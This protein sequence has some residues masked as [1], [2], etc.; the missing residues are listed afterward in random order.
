MSTALA[1]VGA[2]KKV[3]ESRLIIQTL[4]KWLY[5][6]SLENFGQR[7]P[8]RQY[9]ED[10]NLKFD[11]SHLQRLF[12]TCLDIERQFLVTPNSKIVLDMGILKLCM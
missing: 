6:C 2:L 11:I 7:T 9:F 3:E 8:V 1:L 12:D 5:W 4:E 10:G